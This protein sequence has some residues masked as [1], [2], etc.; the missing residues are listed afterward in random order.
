[1]TLLSSVTSSVSGDLA[2]LL[3]AGMTIRHALVCNVISSVLC[4]AG[5]T[6]GVSVGKMESVTEWI[7]AATAGIFLY[8][9]L[10]DMVS[11]MTLRSILWR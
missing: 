2:V 8:I 10:V 5:M 9:A 4:F 11:V 7:F 3:K 6:I 1:M